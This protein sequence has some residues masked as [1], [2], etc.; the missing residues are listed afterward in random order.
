V[1]VILGIAAAVVI[2][3]VD[4]VVLVA[5]GEIVDHS[6]PQVN[7]HSRNKWRMSKKMTTMMMMMIR[8]TGDDAPHHRHHSHIHWNWTSTV[9]GY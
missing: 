3:L 2:V 9:S 5:L 7:L 8:S 4:A 6:P 1:S